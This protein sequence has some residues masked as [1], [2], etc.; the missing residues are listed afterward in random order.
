MVL[1][2]SWEVNSMDWSENG[3]NG[4][5]YG[6]NKD[7]KDSVQRLPCEGTW[8]G[9]RRITSDCEK[10]IKPEEDFVLFSMGKALQAL[11]RKGT[12]I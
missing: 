7:T 1:V 12:N 8:A 3:H 2:G 9:N 6:E 4:L 11:E 5:C 10:E